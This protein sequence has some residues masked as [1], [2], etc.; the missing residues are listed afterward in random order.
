[1][2][3]DILGKSD[4]ARSPKSKMRA[5]CPAC[6]AW[7]HL[8]DT[9]EVWD[10]VNCPECDTLLEVVELRPPT[11]DY[12]DSGLEAEEWEEDWDEEDFH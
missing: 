9:V 10:V 4:G 3:E 2:N 6:S 7:V 5:R 8:R 11:V 12:A 1:M